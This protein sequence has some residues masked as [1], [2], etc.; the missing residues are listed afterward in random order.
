MQ[1]EIIMRVIHIEIVIM[2]LSLMN[3]SN[4]KRPIGILSS[5]GLMI[6]TLHTSLLK[7]T[8]IIFGHKNFVI[9]V[10]G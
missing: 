1:Q 5:V 9:L 4:Y 10:D 6:G 8:A 7:A 2:Q 3:W